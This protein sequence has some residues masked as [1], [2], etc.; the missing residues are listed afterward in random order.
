MV[1]DRAAARAT[2][3]LLYL[4]A[5]ALKTSRAP[6]KANVNPAWYVGDPRLMPFYHTD[7]L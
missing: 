4:P 1:A 7:F 2:A 6:E 3:K 5:H